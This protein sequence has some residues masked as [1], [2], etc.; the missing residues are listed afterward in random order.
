MALLCHMVILAKGAMKVLRRLVT[1]VKYVSMHSDC[2]CLLNG[3]GFI[4][5]CDG[6]RFHSGKW[7]HLT[8]HFIMNKVETSC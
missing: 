2:I 1:V 8:V 4:E 3:P 6:G 5:M 7:R